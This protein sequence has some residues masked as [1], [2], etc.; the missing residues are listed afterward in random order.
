MKILRSTLVLLFV[1]VSMVLTAQSAFDS[2]QFFLTDKPLELKL[3]TDMAALINGKYNDLTQ[4]AKFTCVLP[5]SS[6]LNEDITLT[7][8]GHMRRSICSVPPVKLNFKG[9][10]SA[11][12]SSLKN[13]KLVSVCRGGGFDAQL[14]LKEF[15]IYKIYNLLTDKSFR[16]RRVNLVYEDSKNKKKPLVQDAFFIENID[17]LAKRNKCKELNLVKVNMEGTDRK[18]MTLVN[19]FEFMI[20]NTDWSI[21]NNHNIKLIRSKKDS[22]ARPFPVPYDFDY[23]GLVN[24]EYAIPDPSMNLESVLIRVYRG[25]PRSLEELQSVIELFKQQK[26]NIYSLIRDFQPLSA[27]NKTEMTGYLN[28]FYKIINKPSEIKYYFIDNARTQ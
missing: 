14:L 5:D 1:S 15:L 4:K 21:F 26:D 6:V 3:T 9:S 19:L 24:A 23:S 10:G 16:V 27:I 2:V 22:L 7:V 17:A 28:E 13:L 8:R 18:Q 12:L 25:F 11:R 20:G